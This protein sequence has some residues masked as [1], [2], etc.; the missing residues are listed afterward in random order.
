MTDFMTRR[1]VLACAVA[2]TCA[3]LSGAAL[4]E[5]PQQAQDMVAKAVALF[6]EKGEAAF[7]IFNQGEASGFVD[8]EVYIV[9]ESVGPDAKVLAHAANSTLVGTPLTEILDENGKAF[10]LEMS[11]Q[12]TADGA[13]FD[14]I[15]H[16]PAADKVQRK[17]AWAV[18]HEG[19]VFIAGIYVE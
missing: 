9:V 6:D 18:L 12:A 11:Q 13:W 7:A 19:L 3:A 17:E 2:V 15:W 4:A 1:S 14:Y 5:T 16:N 8:G 10:G